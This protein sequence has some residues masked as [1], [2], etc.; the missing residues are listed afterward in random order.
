MTQHHT[1][2]K[3]SL[4]LELPSRQ[5]AMAIQEKIGAVC[6]DSL[7]DALQELL[8]SWTDTGTLLRVERLEIDLGPCTAQQLERELPERIILYLRERYPALRQ[9]PSLETGME[10]YPMTHGY[11]DS[12]LYFLEYGLLPHTSPVQD[13]VAWEAGVLGVLATDTSALERCRRV[14]ETQPAAINRMVLQFSRQFIRQWIQAYAG[15]AQQAVMQM[16]KVWEHCCDE[17]AFIAE[18]RKAADIAGV[19]LPSLPD[20]SILQRS[21]D[22]WSIRQII[23]SSPAREPAAWLEQLIALSFG[24]A[25]LPAYVH[26]LRQLP[27]IP[28]EGSALMKAALVELHDRHVAAAKISQPAKPAAPQPDNKAAATKDNSEAAQRSAAAGEAAAIAGEATDAERTSVK[29]QRDKG[30]ARTDQTTNDAVTPADAREPFTASVNDNGTDISAVAPP[31]QSS[32]AVHARQ[33]TATDAK[34]TGTNKEEQRKKTGSPPQGLSTYINNAGL[35]LLHPY[36]HIFF[37]TLGLLEKRAFR[38]AAA[39]YKAVQLLG[40]LASGD[41]NIPEYDLVFPKLLCGLLP[42]D[43]VDRFVEL[44]AFDKTEAD[45]LLEAVINHWNALGGTSADGLRGNFLMRE[46]KLQWQGDEWRL[47]VTQTSYDLLLNRLPWGLSVIRLTWMP[48][49]LKTEWA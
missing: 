47:R 39:Q 1:I 23:S 3:L 30:D 6:K 25:Q 36:L 4:E 35:V 41:T 2:G 8:D 45:Q 13:T 38:S 11:F 34:P 14:L 40:F 7:A 9:Q 17:A 19:T 24:T 49:V 43:P 16:A 18:L 5:N 31:V 33:T 15:P 10:R 46:G 48:W 29:Q 21:L 20:K 42:E 26:V 44:T 37:D 28:G 22:A 27:S 12:W 32:D